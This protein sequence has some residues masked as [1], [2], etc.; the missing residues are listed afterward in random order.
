MLMISWRL[1][2]AV[3]LVSSSAAAQTT[4]W[5]DPDLQGVYSNQTPVPL[6]RPKELGDKAFFT[7][8]E[9]AEFQRTALPR[10]LAR[11]SGGI[12]TSGELSEIWLETQK[13]RVGPALRTSMVIDPPDGTIP[14]SAEGR[15]RWEAAPTLEGEL[16]GRPVQ[17]NRPEDRT[18]EERCITTGGVFMPNPFYNN[19]HEI[20]QAPGYVAI[21]TEMMHEV[22]V[23]PLDR[24]PPLGSGIRQWLGD[25][26]GW[27]EGRTLVV[28]TRNFNDKRLFRGA[29]K[30]LTLVERFTRVD[31]DTLR[32]Q[33]TIS[34][35]ATFTQP[36]TIENGLWRTGEQLY[37]V[38]C[39]EGNYGLANILSGARAQER[40]GASGRE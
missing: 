33:L 6:E 15:K 5:G 24:R 34:D 1:V 32:Y 21:V 35:P 17:A 16:A 11:V 29:T 28:E 23:I 31:A 40:E 26:R 7:A 13:G 10:L 39:H 4:P 20:V 38:A 18:L 36:W 30:D 9:A 12:P 22:R 19:Y 14:Y 2:L 3:L 8:A 25:S 27:W 37:E